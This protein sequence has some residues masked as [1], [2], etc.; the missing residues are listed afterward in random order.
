MSATQRSTG[1]MTYVPSDRL[2]RLI[3]LGGLGVLLLAVVVVDVYDVGGFRAL[4]GR[5]SGLSLWHHFFKEG[6]VA[7]WLQAAALLAV[8][9]YAGVGTARRDDADGRAQT[10]LFGILA[11]GAALMVIEDSGNVS[12]TLGAWVNAVGGLPVAAVRMPVF[13]LIALVMVYGPWRYRA[14]LLRRPRILRTFVIGYAFYAFMVLGEI[15][16]QLFPF[17][18]RVGG[19][20]RETLFG[21][22]MLPIELPP[23]SGDTLGLT[24]ADVMSFFLMDYVY[25]E[26]L[27]LI[28][29]SFLLVAV[30]RLVRRPAAEDG[31]DQVADGA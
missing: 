1:R 7:E 28:G 11:L 2:V 24:G 6:S 13:G 16:N 3:L 26:S 5:N 10:A 15:L 21:G 29:A 31:S 20:V 9:Y 27:E 14:M 23:G 19:W 25:E 30:L 17:Y 12:Q 22:R 18:V 8:V 4:V